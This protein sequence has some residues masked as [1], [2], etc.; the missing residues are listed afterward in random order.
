MLLIYS[1]DVIINY[2]TNILP[3][4]NFKELFVDIRT[5]LHCS[6]QLYVNF[7]LMTAKYFAVTRSDTR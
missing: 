6:L 5:K 2:T 3:C 7:R 4:N 1:D